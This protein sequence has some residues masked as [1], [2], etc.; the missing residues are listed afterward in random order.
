MS[1]VLKWELWPSKQKKKLKTD[2]EKWGGCHESSE[3]ELRGRLRIK[4]EVKPTRTV[5]SLA[6]REGEIEIDDGP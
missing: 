6:K 2:D 3:M 5:D 1:S 4:F